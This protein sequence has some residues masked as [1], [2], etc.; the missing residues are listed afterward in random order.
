MTKVRMKAVQIHHERQLQS[1]R[2]CQPQAPKDSNNDEPQKGF[3]A[4]RNTCTENK[5][6]IGMEAPVLDART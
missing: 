5:D 6:N 2:S 3:E 4:S 1:H